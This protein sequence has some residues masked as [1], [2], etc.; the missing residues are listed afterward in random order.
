MDRSSTFT[1]EPPGLNDEYALTSVALDATDWDLAFA[2]LGRDPVDR[3]DSYAM[4]FQRDVNRLAD[5]ASPWN[6]AREFDDP[7]VVELNHA[8][9]VADVPA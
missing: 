9:L 2:A 8:L 7:L 3:A 6:L 5:L 1:P 4:R